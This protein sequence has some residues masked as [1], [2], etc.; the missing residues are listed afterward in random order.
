MATKGKA[1]LT[2]LMTK[3]LYYSLYIFWSELRKNT[4]LC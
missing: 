3:N 1:C 4:S 2:A